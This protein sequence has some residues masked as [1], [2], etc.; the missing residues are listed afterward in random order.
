MSGKM[1]DWTMQ[2]VLLSEAKIQKILIS[3]L[4]FSW[5][6]GKQNSLMQISRTVCHDLL[7]KI[8]HIYKYM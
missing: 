5:V 2:P 8:M 3:Y 1:F 6:G 7:Y 4:Q